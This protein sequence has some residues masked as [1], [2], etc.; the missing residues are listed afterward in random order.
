MISTYKHRNSVW[1]DLENPTQDEVRSLALKYGI[2]PYIANELLVPTQRSRVDY[3][4]DYIYVILHFPNSNIDKASSSRDLNEI[5][6]IIGKNFI[7]TTRYNT[8]DALHD[9]SKMFEVNSILDRKEVSEHAGF[10][11]FF[12][13]QN[14]YRS[15]LGQL[16]HIQDRLSESEERIFNGEEKFMV[17]ELS[18]LQRIILRFKETIDEHQEVLEAFQMFGKKFFDDA[19]SFY[20]VGINSEYKKVKT[21]LNSRTEYLKEL[22]KTNDSLLNTKQNEIMK[23]LTIMTSILLP[24][25]LISGIFGMNLPSPLERYEE[26]FIFVMFIMLISLVGM[27]LFFKNK[28]WL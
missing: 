22:Q 28:K 5:D 9:F 8:V 4:K 19:F 7:I 2:D 24:L 21:T 12:M 16:E 13:I 15:L 20:L 26:G 10:L 23:T 14:L 1:I 25:S 6:F 3:N 17:V 27:S 18:K 11:F